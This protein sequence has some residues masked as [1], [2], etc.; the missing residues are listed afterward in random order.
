MVPNLYPPYVS[1]AQY[2]ANREMLQANQ[3]NFVSAKPRQGIAPANRPKSP[4]QP[5]AP[6]RRG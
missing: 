4:N 5:R 3:Y 6:Q 2:L 1:E